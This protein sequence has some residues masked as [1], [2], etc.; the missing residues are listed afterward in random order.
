MKCPK[1]KADTS[2][3]DSRDHKLDHNETT[4]RR[5]RCKKCGHRFSTIEILWEPLVKPAGLPKHAPA[6]GYKSK[7]K[8]LP[9][10]SPRYEKHARDRLAMTEQS[11]HYAS[12]IDADFDAL[13]DEQLEQAIFEGRVNAD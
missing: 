3:K 5:R 6:A 11:R 1:C 10:A 2:V 13:S 4:R 8:D 9:K 12:F 7:R